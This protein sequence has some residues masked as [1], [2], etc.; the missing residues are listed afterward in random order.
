MASM[1]SSIFIERDPFTKIILFDFKF[2]FK[3]SINY[4]LEEY[5]KFFLIS[6]SVFLKNMPN[7]KIKSIFLFSA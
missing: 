3:D 4:Y 1:I 2:F 7:L 6:L 5:Q